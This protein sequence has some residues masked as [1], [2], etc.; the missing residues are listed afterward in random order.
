MPAVLSTVP[1]VAKILATHVTGLAKEF[2]KPAIY[3]TTRLPKSL[4]FSVNAI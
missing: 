1:C 2:L 4:M 3:G